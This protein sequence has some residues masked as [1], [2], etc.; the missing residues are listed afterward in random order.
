MFARSKTPEFLIHE[1]ERSWHGLHGQSSE[2]GVEIFFPPYPSRLAL[3]PTQPP[4]QSV[5]GGTNKSL[6]RPGRKQ[7]TATKLGIYSTYYP[8][9][10]KH[11]VALCYSFCKPLKKK[12]RMLSGQPGLRG[13]NGLGVGRKMA[14]F[15]FFFFSP[16]NRW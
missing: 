1:S 5:R 8:R 10:S 16:G 12:F 4:V 9:S 15:Q 14:T 3:G 13:S 11:F 7:A 2:L 6:P